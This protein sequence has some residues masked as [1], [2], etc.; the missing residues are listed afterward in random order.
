ME[1]EEADTKPGSPPQPEAFPGE[2]SWANAVFCK[3][4]P[5]MKGNSSLLVISEG[6]PG[7][8]PVLRLS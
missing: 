3:E 6:K 7:W 2:A 4:I 8:T 1:G 5:G